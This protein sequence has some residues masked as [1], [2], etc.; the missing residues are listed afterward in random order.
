M[1]FTVDAYPDETFTGAISQ[2]RI[3]STIT[4]SVVTYDVVVEALNPQMKLLPGMTANLTFQISVHDNV[5][6]VPNIALRFFPD[7]GTGAAR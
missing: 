3:T 5:L 7:R 1:T 6:R 4:S 2:V